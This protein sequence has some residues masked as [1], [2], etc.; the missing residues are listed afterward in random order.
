[1]TE[2]SKIMFVD[3]EPNVLRALDR[4]FIDDEYEIITA[5][6]GEEGL[7]MLAE[8]PDIKVVVSDYRMPGLNGVD[9]LRAVCQSHPETVRIVL[10]GYAD[11][12][13]VVSAINEGQIYRFIPKPW[14]D[15]EVRTT[16]AKAIDLFDFRSHNRELI[17]QYLHL[18]S[19]L[20][21]HSR[22]LENTII[23][24][25]AE[26]TL[27]TRAL[28]HTAKIIGWLP[29]GILVIVA[30]ETVVQTNEAAEYLLAQNE[31]QQFLG[32]KAGT[33]LP[34]DLYEFSLTVAAAKGTVFR[35]L[36]IGGRTILVWGRA[37][38]E[39]GN[40]A[41]ILTLTP[42]GETEEASCA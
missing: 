35:Q 19:E 10:S 14:D 38:V 41:V 22:K 16:I 15:G 36:V 37:V 9:F 25:T 20:Q 12:A 13:A 2:F 24:R 33:I 32:E 31:C 28:E 6:S 23:H 17:D 8:N 27:N 4:V 26:L 40:L 3:D 5:S 30:D 34:D 18:N 42:T 7:E 11:T 39:D 29:V 1:M 21:A